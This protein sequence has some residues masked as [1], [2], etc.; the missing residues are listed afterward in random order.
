MRIGERPNAY[1]VYCCLAGLSSRR[2]EKINRE[3]NYNNERN[4]ERPHKTFL[5]S[6]CDVIF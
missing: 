6:G 1:P 3:T 4:K 5:N 2:G